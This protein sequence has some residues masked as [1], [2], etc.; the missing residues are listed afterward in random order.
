M[1]T[2]TTATLIGMGVGIGFGVLRLYSSESEADHWSYLVGYFALWA[3]IG[4]LI[5]YIFARMWR[6]ATTPRL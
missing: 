5:G 1:W 2:R 3:F 6:D 4:G